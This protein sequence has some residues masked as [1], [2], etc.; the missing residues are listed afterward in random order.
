MPKIYHNFCKFYDIMGFMKKENNVQGEA[1]TASQQKTK[2]LN[3][4]EIFRAL[5]FLGFSISAGVIQIISFTLLYDVI[6]WLWW[7]SYLISIILSVVWNFTFNRKFTFKSANNV[8][9]AMAWTLLYYAAFIPISVFGGDALENIGWNGTL[10]TF[11]MMVINFVTEFL[12][13][14]FFVFRKSINSKPLPKTV[15]MKLSPSAYED[16]VSGDKRVEMRANDEKRKTLLKGDHILFKNQEDESKFFK[17]TITA[18]KKFDSFD[19]L[20]KNYD[21]KDLGYKADEEASPQDMQKYYSPEDVND[22][23]LAIEVKFNKNKAKV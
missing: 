21:K 13:Q 5:K 6:H 16:F 7:P 12:W 15:E 19:E 10:V 2:K 20:Y 23:V 3:K 22:G 17:A 9:I 1:Q 8:P 4:E 14:R 11:I 18:I